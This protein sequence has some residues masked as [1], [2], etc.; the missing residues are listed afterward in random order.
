MKKS[1]VLLFTAVLLLTLAGC[2]PVVS[3][4]PQTSPT[5]T[6]ILNA[7]GDVDLQNSTYAENASVNTADITIENAD[8]GG[9]ILTVNAPGVT[10]RNISNADLVIGAGVDDGDVFVESC[11]FN[12]VTVNG[13]GA[14][15]IHFRTT[16]ITHVDV[17]K[18]DVRVVLEEGTAIETAKINADNAKLEAA[19]TDEED[20]TAVPASVGTLEV[21]DDTD[22]VVI[23]KVTAT[24]VVI[25]ENVKTLL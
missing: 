24:A 13:G 16:T 14:N 19:V 8:L 23:Q 3:S 25:K 22:G 11:A 21:A 18:H 5:L 4:L 7:G 9:K 12:T 20:E 10:L 17:Q 2:G 1:I 15:S 6:S